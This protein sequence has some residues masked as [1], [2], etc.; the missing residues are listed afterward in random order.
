MFTP[1]YNF[2]A[3]PPQA[4]EFNKVGSTDGYVTCIIVYCVTEQRHHPSLRIGF[5]FSIPVFGFFF[6]HQG[7]GIGKGFG[8][9]PLYLRGVRCSHHIMI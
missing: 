2:F 6:R 8:S 3:Q 7:P 4:S 9:E 5:T 1:H